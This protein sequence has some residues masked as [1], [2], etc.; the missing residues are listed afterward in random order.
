MRAKVPTDSRPSAHAAGDKFVIYQY[1]PMVTQLPA[2]REHGVA[3][4]PV[5]SVQAAVHGTAQLNRPP[6]GIG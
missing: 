1:A 4:V 5:A 2:M 3:S 6:P